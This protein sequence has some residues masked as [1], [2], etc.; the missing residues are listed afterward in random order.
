LSAL[1]RTFKPKE[2]RIFRYFDGQKK[3][4]IDPLEAQLALEAADVDWEKKLLDFRIY[5]AMDEKNETVVREAIEAAQDIV[6]VVRKAF[7]IPEYDAEAEV[8]LT[9][10]ELLDLVAA[11]IG[12]R[13]DVQ[14]SFESSQ[15]SPRS[16]DGANAADTGNGSDCGST[17]PGSL[18]EK[19]PS[20]PA[21]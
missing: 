14:E 4:G 5:A 7:K 3:R 13:N 21:A 19:H 15:T 6:A 1:D 18:P 11:F 8:G 10:M 16:T 9:L 12:W 17:S 20:L 2:R